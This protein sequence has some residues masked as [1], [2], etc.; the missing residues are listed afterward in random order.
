M[1]LRPRT[2][3]LAWI[4]LTA[5]FVVSA[6]L[7]QQ[8]LKDAG[9]RYDLL[10][11]GTQREHPEI[12]L[13]TILPGGLR[14]VAV[15]GLWIRAEKYKQE[16]RFY[17]AM[18]LAELICTLQP[19]FPTVWSFQS[20]NMAWNISV[21]THTPEERWYWV[22]AGLVLLR[23]RGIPENPQALELYRDLAWIFFFKMGQTTDEMH[24]TYKQRWAAQ[25]QRLLGAPPYADTPEVIKAFMPIAGALLDKDIHRQGLEKIQS[26]K[27]QEVLK[28]PAAAQYALLLVQQGIHIDWSL[29]DAYNRYSIE[30]PAAVVRVRRPVLATEKDKAL[31]ALIN[32][33]R[34]A[35]ARAKLLAFVR[36]Q[37]LWNEYKMDPQWMVHLMEEYGP[38]DWRQVMPH[39]LYWVSYGFKVCKDVS[40]TEIGALN[41][42]RVYLNCLRYLTTYGRMTY[43]QNPKDPE[44]PFI[45]GFPDWRYIVPAQREHVRAGELAAKERGTTFADNILKDGH[46]N[47]LASAIQLLYAGYRRDEAQYYFDWVK[48]AYKMSGGDW[49]L[50]LEDWV[51][52]QIKSEGVPV[53]AQARGLIIASLEAAFVHLL[54][55]DKDGYRRS[56]LFSKQVYDTYQARAPARNRFPGLEIFARDVLTDL[57]AEPRMSGYNISMQSRIQLYGLVGQVWPGLEVLVYDLVAA[58][59]KEQCDSEGLDFQRAFPPPMGLEEYRRELERQGPPQPR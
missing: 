8:P 32:D 13:L 41:T 46:V 25:M 59:L 39:G 31:S 34:Y 52:S 29:L 10:A 7:L 35:G 36:A 56:L 33:P 6:G 12:T 17:D 9:T 30:D 57:L 50:P 2:I 37:L 42:E 45:T 21:A 40:L 51:M 5:G 48:K 4:V 49:D 58:P 19:S 1:S 14:A 18:Q 27:L 55:N 43:I 16:G 11:A 54:I 26:G 3:Q 44:Q 47:Y 23:D 38:L 28:D 15:N 22:S 53:S 24:M 20:W